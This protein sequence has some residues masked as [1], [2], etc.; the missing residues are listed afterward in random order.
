MNN[1]GRPNSSSLTTQSE[2]LS[3]GRFHSVQGTSIFVAAITNDSERSAN[4]SARAVRFDYAVPNLVFLDGATLSSHTLFET[5][6]NVIL[7]LSQF[8]SP[9]SDGEVE[10]KW[11]VYEVATQ[12]TNSDG[13]VNSE[14]LFSVSVSGVNGLNYAE[15][16]VNVERIYGMDLLESQVLLLVY[17]TTDGHLVSKVDL[18]QQIIL[19]TQMLTQIPLEEVP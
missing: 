19:E 18:E 5:N 15:L 2:S 11:L 12:D 9:D 17:E 13:A 10:V 4:F 14:D 3:I 1:T 8:P 6:D 16:I 7:G